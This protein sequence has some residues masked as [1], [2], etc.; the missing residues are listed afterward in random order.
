MGRVV[1]T[2]YLLY[3]DDSR[4]VPTLQEPWAKSKRD[5]YA[6]HAPG[7]SSWSNSQCL[8]RCSLLSPCP[9][10]AVP[11][12]NLA[13]HITCA[14]G[15]TRVFQPG[16]HQS[17]FCVNDK[18]AAEKYHGF[19]T[20][21]KN[22]TSIGLGQSLQEHGKYS[23]GET[24]NLVVN[25]ADVQIPAYSLKTSSGVCANPVNTMSDC[26]LAAQYL[27]LQSQDPGFNGTIVAKDISSSHRPQYCS[28]YDSRLYFNSYASTW[29]CSASEQCL[30]QGGIIVLTPLQAVQTKPLQ[31]QEV[32]FQLSAVGKYRLALT[33]GASSTED[34]LFS[35]FTLQCRSDHQRSGAGCRLRAICKAPMQLIEGQCVV[36]R[37]QATIAS[38]SVKRAVTKP[39]T[40]WKRVRAAPGNASVSAS[41]DAIQIRIQPEAEFSFNWSVQ[42]SHQLHKAIKLEKTRGRASQ[43]IADSTDLTFVPSELHEIR[44]GEHV[45]QS[46]HFEGKAPGNVTVS[47]LAVE[48]DLTVHALP[49]IQNSSLTLAIGDQSRF[50][51]PVSTLSAKEGSSVRMEIAAV[52]EGGFP[53]SKVSEL[54]FVMALRHSK[55]GLSDT[56]SLEMRYNTECSCFAGILTFEAGVGLYTAWIQE[57]RKVDGTVYAAGAASDSTLQCSLPICS[58]GTGPCMP[59]TIKVSL[60]FCTE[61]GLL[62][63]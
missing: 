38:R 1:P 44:E 43:S 6:M 11:V 24:T 56:T 3:T 25:T 16:S 4:F 42:N 19:L 29:P 10:S 61:C 46:L 9:L 27:K 14:D 47:M 55:S 22:R 54:W 18:S 26:S 59:L 17:G 30:C 34:V 15:V 40:G 49:S 41:V 53:I 52:D 7:S 31:Q 58:Q 21:L 23:I 45:R 20:G 5:L 60:D 2:A 28:Y 63:K 48:V 12:V 37:A 51:W 32:V 8:D 62:I 39:S 50:T 57:I 36:A 35:S 13:P 33:T